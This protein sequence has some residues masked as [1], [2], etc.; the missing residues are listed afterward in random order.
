MG[1]PKKRRVLFVCIGNACRSPMAESVALHHAKDVIEPSSAG[2][3]AFGSIVDSTRE[4]LFA[5]GYP[6]EGLSSK[7]LSFEALQQADL[8]VNMTGQP[9]GILF[10]GLSNVEDWLVEDPYGAD[11]AT[12]QKILEEIESRVLLLAARL[13]TQRSHSK[14]RPKPRSFAKG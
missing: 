6:T 8:I 1:A 9:S 5:K 4:A 13:R 10:P 14:N 7:T 3:H 11:P 2:L 12:Y